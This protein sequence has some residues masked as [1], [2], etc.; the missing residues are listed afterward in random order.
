MHRFNDYRMP[1]SPVEKRV[2]ELPKGDGQWPGADHVWKKLQEAA[3]YLARGKH[4]RLG[5]DHVET[6]AVLGTGHEETMKYQ[7]SIAYVHGWT[8][9]HIG[10]GTNHAAS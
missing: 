6:M 4:T 8:R 3:H 7:L 9:H 1:L 10:G 5:A 2:A